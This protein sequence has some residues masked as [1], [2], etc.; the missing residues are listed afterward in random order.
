[1]EFCEAMV[2]HFTDD[3]IAF[4]TG[5]R[6]KECIARMSKKGGLPQAALAVDGCH[7]PITAP[8]ENPENFIIEK[9][10]IR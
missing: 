4:P 7:I 3:W 5:V 9:G 1:M 8:H 6:I 2:Q 10:F